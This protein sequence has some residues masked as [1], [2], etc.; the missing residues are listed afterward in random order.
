MGMTLIRKNNPPGTP[1][2][3]ELFQVFVG[4]GNNP[5]VHR[6]GPVVAHSLDNFFLEDPKQFHLSGK[7]QVADLVQKDVPPVGCFKS[8]FPIPVCSG[9]GAPHVAEELALQQGFGQRRAV[10]LDEGLLSSGA[11]IME[12]SGDQFLSGPALSVNNHRGIG[13]RRI[14]DEIKTC[15][16]A[17]ETPT[18]P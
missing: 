6:D 4:G 17:A 9:V 13:G 10:D 1:R 2:G 8:P 11:D 14:R 12:G 18:I 15:S 16:I 7:R 3:Y 5:D